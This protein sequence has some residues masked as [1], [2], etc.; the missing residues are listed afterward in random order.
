L[1]LGNINRFI[2]RRILRKKE[3]SISDNSDSGTSPIPKGNWIIIVI[4]IVI[5]AIGFAGAIFYGSQFVKEEVN[6]AATLPYTN[7]SQIK[8]VLPIDL[9]IVFVIIGVIGFGIFTYGFVTRADKPLDFYP[10]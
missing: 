6:A 3:S 8:N 10:K 9:E 1:G 4:G 7:P 5:A 2:T